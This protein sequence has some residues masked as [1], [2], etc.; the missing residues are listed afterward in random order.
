VTEVP[1][2]G[3]FLLAI[4]LRPGGFVS[5]EIDDVSKLSPVERVEVNIIV[6]QMVVLAL[7]EGPAPA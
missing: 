4:P 1:R 3:R 6:C 2:K 7:S 5:I